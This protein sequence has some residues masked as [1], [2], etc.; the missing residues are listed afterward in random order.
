MKTTFITLGILTLLCCAAPSFA[1]T[2]SSPTTSACDGVAGNLVSNC[3]FET[4]SFFSWTLTNTSY[5]PNPVIGSSPDPDTGVESFTFNGM[6]PN[7][8][9]EF[10]ALGDSAQTP[11]TLAQTFTDIAGTNLT[12]SFY[13]ST[14]NTGGSLVADFDGTAVAPAILNNIVSSGYQ[15]YSYAV[16]A[17]GSDTI[18]FIEQ[19][20]IGG[21]IGLDDVVVVD[22]PPPNANVASTPEP[23]S[24]AFAAVTL[25]GLLVLARRRRA[26]AQI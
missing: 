24:L 16:S 23:S 7:S 17:T 8:G 22:P 6:N 25:L 12:F 3:G 2:I 21:Y 1:D 13:V 15:E 9:N 14:D 18:S 11:T 4:N 26:S 19:G 5:N 20:P 10:A